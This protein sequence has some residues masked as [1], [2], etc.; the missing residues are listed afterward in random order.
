[1]AT[2]TV[3]VVRLLARAGGGEAA[4]QVVELILATEGNYRRV[5]LRDDQ[6][7]LVASGALA[8][9]DDVRIEHA[10]PA[11]RGAAGVRRLTA[12]RY[13]RI[14]KLAPPIEP[15]RDV[16]ETKLTVL[17]IAR[18]EKGKV[19]IAGIDE[20]GAWLRPQGV[21]AVELLAA[22]RPLFKNRC[23]STVYLDA[24][25]GRHARKEDRFFVY[26]RGV[27]HELSEEEQRLFLAQ[28]RDESVDAVFT[29]GRS[30]GLIKPRILQVYEERARSKQRE[31]EYEQYIRFNFKDGAG[32]VYR[33]WPCRCAAFY[34]AWTEMKRKHR[35]TCGWRMLT[36]LRRHETYFAIGLTHTD[37]GRSTLEYG[38]YPM[39]VGVHLVARSKRGVPAQ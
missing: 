23:V 15:L 32:R 14:T 4:E 22:T 36:Y 9:S 24:W 10:S 1:M 39:I 5:S 6:P 2:V 18:P 30:L 26:C 17:A 34:D 11:C 38:A 8:V 27:E 37:Y 25:R 21:H 7:A 19:C 35:W 28:H 16:T 31:T 3:K 20:Q 29:H 13:A 12:G 33:R